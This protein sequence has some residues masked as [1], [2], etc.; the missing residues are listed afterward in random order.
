MDCRIKPGNDSGEAEHARHTLGVMRGLD[1]RIRDERQRRWALPYSAHPR[2]SGDP[3]QDSKPGWVPA[4][5]G[6][7]GGGMRNPG[8][9]SRMSLRS[10]GLLATSLSRNGSIDPSARKPPSR[11]GEEIADRLAAVGAEHAAGR[12]AGLIAGEE[13]RRSR[14]VLAGADAAHRYALAPPFVDFRIGI[15]RLGAGRAD[16]TG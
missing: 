1:S 8:S 11:H 5:A 3:E 12:V 4:F 9:P 16:V 2:A 10:C 13:N 15:H 6:T 14:D 7:S